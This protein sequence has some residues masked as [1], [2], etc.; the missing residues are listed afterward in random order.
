MSQFKYSYGHMLISRVKIVFLFISQQSVFPVCNIYNI[1][2]QNGK[3]RI[4]ANRQFL[5][6]VFC[7]GFGV[8]LG[9]IHNSHLYT[10]FKN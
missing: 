7:I 10:S 6:D 8:F 4:D 1:L 3:H 9:N 2:K 5:I